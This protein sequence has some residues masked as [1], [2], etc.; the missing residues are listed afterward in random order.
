[1]KV[2][3]KYVRCLCLQTSKLVNS[4]S[5]NNNGSHTCSYRFTFNDGFMEMCKLW[6]IDVIRDLTVATIVLPLVPFYRRVCAVTLLL[7]RGSVCRKLCAV[8]SEVLVL[9]PLWVLHLRYCLYIH[10]YI[11]NILGACVK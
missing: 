3:V 5:R 10:L 6:S 9:V 2:K 11:V 7:K 8:A 4:Q 1:V